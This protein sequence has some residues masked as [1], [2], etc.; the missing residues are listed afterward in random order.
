M[1]YAA[2]KSIHFYIIRQHFF[3]VY[4]KYRQKNKQ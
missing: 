4:S 3:I 1:Q 2:Y